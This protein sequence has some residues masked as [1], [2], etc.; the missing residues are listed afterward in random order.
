MEELQSSDAIQRFPWRTSP[1]A[2]AHYALRKSPQ[3]DEIPSSHAQ[4]RTRYPRPTRTPGT[5]GGRGDVRIGSMLLD[6]CVIGGVGLDLLSGNPCLVQVG[7][8]LNDG[9]V[10]AVP[11]CQYITV[12]PTYLPPPAF[13]AAD[14]PPAPSSPTESSGGSRGAQRPAFIRSTNAPA[15]ALRPT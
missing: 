13:T 9:L 6:V 2:H 14:D 1:D 3:A 11:A 8:V 7:L 4:D 10:L 15:Y 5:R 12:L